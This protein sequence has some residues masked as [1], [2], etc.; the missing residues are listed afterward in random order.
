MILFSNLHKIFL[1]HFHPNR[2]FFYNTV[3]NFRG[4]L[5]NVSA[6]TAILVL[7]SDLFDKSEMNSGVV[8]I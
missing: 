7:G 3:M 6:K 2:I 4:D 1:G 5:T 8:Q